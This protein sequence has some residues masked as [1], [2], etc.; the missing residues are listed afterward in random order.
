MRVDLVFLLFV[1][2]R[3]LTKF[4]C[5][6]LE[7]VSPTKYNK[8]ENGCVEY[9]F[10]WWL[11]VEVKC[12]KVEECVDSI[13]LNGESESVHFGSHTGKSVLTL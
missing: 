8:E 2:F 6:R 5:S 11:T 9:T 7:K 1:S 12:K 4:L 10:S 13:S 3:I